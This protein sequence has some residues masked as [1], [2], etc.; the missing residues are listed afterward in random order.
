[1]STRDWIG[2]RLKSGILI[3]R[4]LNVNERH[5]KII[6]IV[7]FFFV[8]FFFIYLFFIFVCLFITRFNLYAVHTA[9]I[10]LSWKLWI[11]S[12]KTVNIYMKSILKKRIVF[13]SVSLSV[14]HNCQSLTIGVCRLKKMIKSYVLL[15]DFSTLTFAY[16][17]S[18]WV[19]TVK[20]QELCHYN[21]QFKRNLRR[22]YCIQICVWLVFHFFFLFCYRW[23]LD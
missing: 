1:M 18:W 19:F 15:Y 12:H 5:H 8:C 17:I 14:S 11:A 3:Q 16:V 6:S 13:G 2:W 21:M 22:N 10:L 7:F 23:I 4:G 9:T 20:E